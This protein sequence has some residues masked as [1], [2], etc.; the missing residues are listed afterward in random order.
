M[1]SNDD[2]NTDGRSLNDMAL[3][4]SNHFIEYSVTIKDETHSLTVRDTSYH[5]IVLSTD[6]PLLQSLVQAA[7]E[8]FEY[9]P[10]MEAPEIIVKFKMIWQS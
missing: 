7:L 6:N 9:D 1:T 2:I 5:P 8:Q 3:P 10:L 4:Q